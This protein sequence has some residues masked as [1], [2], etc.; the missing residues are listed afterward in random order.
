MA[1][2]LLRKNCRR[3]AA[4]SS[5]RS[6]RQRILDAAIPLFY[7]EGARAV[8]IDTIIAKSGVAKMSLY[9]SFRSKDELI[10]ACLQERDKIYWRW[11]DRVVA[12]HPGDPREQLRVVICGIAKRTSRPGYRGCFFLNTATDYADPRHPGRK[13][14]VRHKE[15]LASRLLKIC[16]Q[17]GV[18]DPLAL[19]RQLLLLING[20]QATAGML[21]RKTQMELIAAAEQLIGGAPESRR[22][23]AVRLKNLTQRT[24]RRRRSG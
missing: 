19:S 4:D 22:V 13:L 5:V 6:A 21:G 10:A 9:R 8:G 15:T 1:P 23:T 20:A 2:K 24:Q 12:L 7:Q 3:P 18:R 17:L 16:R 11:F 14:A